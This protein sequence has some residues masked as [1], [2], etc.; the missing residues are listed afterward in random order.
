VEVLTGKVLVDEKN[1]HRRDTDKSIS[2]CYTEGI[3]SFM[4]GSPAARSSIMTAPK[5]D[6][7]S[8]DVLFVIHVS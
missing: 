8:P 5:T 4:R 6:A 1:L 3:F 7:T 2:P